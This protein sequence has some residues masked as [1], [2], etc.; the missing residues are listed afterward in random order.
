MADMTTSKVLCNS[1]ISKPN[2]SYMCYDIKNLYLVIP[3]VRY[4]YIRLA[5][6][7]I[8]EYIIKAYN[9]CEIKVNRW[10]YCEI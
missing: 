4:E 3:M 7:L 5:I 8:P 2:G 10:V 6:A 9:I 1:V